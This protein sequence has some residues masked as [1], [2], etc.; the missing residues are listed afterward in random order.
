VFDQLGTIGEDLG[1]DVGIVVFR[2]HDI[3]EDAPLLCRPGHCQAVVATGGGDDP[4]FFDLRRRMSH[5]IDR[6]SHLE[7]I[8]GKMV[9]MLDINEGVEFFR[10]PLVIGQVGS[11]EHPLYNLSGFEDFEHIHARDQ[12]VIMMLHGFS[13]SSMAPSKG[14]LLLP[15]EVR[16]QRTC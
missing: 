16:K 15:A 7:G 12:V 2:D 14:C 6:P 1:I 13:L 9:F 3:A 4:L 8:G 5:E 10:K 11:L